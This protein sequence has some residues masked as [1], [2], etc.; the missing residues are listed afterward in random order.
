MRVAF[1]GGDHRLR[2][3]LDCQKDLFGELVLAPPLAVGH[4][5]ALLE[6]AAGRER[7]AAGTGEDQH[8]QGV[9]KSQFM[10][11]LAQLDEHLRVHRIHHLGPVQHQSANAVSGISV[12]RGFDAQGS[13]VHGREWRL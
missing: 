9:V 1:D 10:Q 6:V 2:K 12:G 11:G 13:V 4:P 3:I 8:A 7:A 5:V